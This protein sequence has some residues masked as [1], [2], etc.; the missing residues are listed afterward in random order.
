MKKKQKREEKSNE[1]VPTKWVERHLTCLAKGCKAERTMKLP[2]RI[3][4]DGFLC[5]QCFKN[6]Q[7]GK[8]LIKR[9]M[10]VYDRADEE[11]WKEHAL[12]LEKS[13]KRLMKE[14]TDREL[15][16]ATSS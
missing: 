5:N 13:N 7:H 4:G 2:E 8:G 9:D 3:K 1:T 10:V 15:I 11:T 16:E 6:W 12:E 14:V